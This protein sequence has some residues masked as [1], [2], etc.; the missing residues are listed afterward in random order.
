[1]PGIE[2][3]QDDER[4]YQNRRLLCLSLGWLL[5][6]ISLNP[7]QVLRAVCPLKQ[8]ANR[9]SSESTKTSGDSGCFQPL[10]MKCLSSRFSGALASKILSEFF[11]FV[12]E[13]TLGLQLPLFGLCFERSPLKGSQQRERVGEELVSGFLGLVGF[14]FV[15]FFMT[16]AGMF[17]RKSP[18][19]TKG[20]SNW[21]PYS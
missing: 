8:F 11:L 6:L 21:G 16:F 4:L 17:E 12:K 20:A 18:W 19:S 2:L 13:R 7:Q 10:E 15:C 3:C 14:L 9:S 5:W 1:M